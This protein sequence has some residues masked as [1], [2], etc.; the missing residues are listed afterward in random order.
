MIRVQPL[1]C[2][3]TVPDRNSVATEFYFPLRPYSC[4][5][6]VAK[7]RYGKGGILK[8][9]VVKIGKHKPL[10]VFD[11]KGEWCAHITQPNYASDDPD[12][13]DEYK[14][15]RDFTFKLEEFTLT[16]DWVSLGFE[17]Y[18]ARQL[19]DIFVQTMHVHKGV[20]DRFMEVI[21]DLP[22]KDDHIP[23]FNEKYGTI[24][25][26]AFNWSIVTQ[27][28]RLNLPG[29]LK[30]F[31]QG[32]SDKRPIYNFGEEW[33]K[34]RNIFLDFNTGDWDTEVIYRNQTFAGKIL[35]KLRKYHKLIKGFIVMEE[36]DFILPYA[37]SML[38]ASSVQEVMYLAAKAPKEGVGMA[39]LMQTTQQ[40]DPQIFKRGSWQRLF[41]QFD[42]YPS[43]YPRLEYDP[44]GNYREFLFVDVNG[45]WKKITPLVPCCRYESNIGGGLDA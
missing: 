35:H 41:G 44:D 17:G 4:I 14:I 29:R 22:T 12:F 13:V 5:G 39:L 42:D 2:G 3:M 31:W 26:G 8:P 33:I 23:L 32:P 38:K 16:Q 15:Y 11:F 10:L 7:P 20:P 25:Q 27:E 37:R 9:L 6:G 1:L 43:H 24:I 28:Y 19:R 30:W 21:N 36:C 18:K 34:H 45:R 40:V